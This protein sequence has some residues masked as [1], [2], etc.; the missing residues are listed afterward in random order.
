[1]NLDKENYKAVVAAFE[2]NAGRKVM[3]ADGNN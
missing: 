3:T 2:A 1:L